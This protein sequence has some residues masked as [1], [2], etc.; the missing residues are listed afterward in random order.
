MSKT[1][2]YKCH[3]EIEVDEMVIVHPLCLSC[4]VAWLEWFDT[5]LA[6]LDGV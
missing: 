2:C 3:T 4:E 6:I 5:Q 1:T